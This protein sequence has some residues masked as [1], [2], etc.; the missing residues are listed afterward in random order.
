MDEE[1]GLG[2]VIQSFIEYTSQ[3]KFTALPGVVLKVHNKGTQQLLD[4]QPSVSIRGRDGVVTDQ[5]T[6]LN[7]PYQQPASSIGGM[8]FPIHPGDNVLLVYSMRGID[9]WKRGDG[10]LA[11]ASDYRMFSNLD[12]IAIPCI[13]PVSNTPTSGRHTSGYSIGDVAVYNARN[14]NMCEI[15]LKADGDVIV[16]SP[17]KVTINCQNSEVN[18]A[19][20]VV[21]NA[22]N[23]AT[24]RAGRDAT[25][26]AVSDVTVSAGNDATVTAESDA[27]VN[28]GNDVVVT[29]GG[30]M[31]VSGP[32]G[33]MT[34][35]GG[36]G[37]AQVI[38][39]GPLLIK[40]NTGVR[41]KGPSGT[42]TL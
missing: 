10:G 23:D 1:I 40:S 24:I 15:I 7:V 39:S 14:G 41:I 29:A 13:S 16:N 6:V 42:L 38:S 36:G 25:V 21:T 4:V 17:G 8:V 33:Q 28:A 19:N 32:A 35:G 18:A 9:T 20:D 37:Y 31:V 27:I 30:D 26:T 12:C 34:L 22:G 3:N 11:P 2:E 5:A